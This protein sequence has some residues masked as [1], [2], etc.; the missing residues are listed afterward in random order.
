MII[1]ASVTSAT[2]A[3]PRQ[4]QD[5]ARASLAMRKYLLEFQQ[6]IVAPDRCLFPVIAAVHG[7]V[8]GLGMD[9]ISACDIR[10]AARDAVFSIKVRSPSFI[11]FF[12]SN[13][14]R[15]STSVLHQT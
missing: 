3:S 7:A 4:P 11:I 8:I 12:S 6:A 5:S 14:C 2:A 9:L 1:L 15:K 13:K 10:Y